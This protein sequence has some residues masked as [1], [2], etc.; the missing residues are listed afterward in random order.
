MAKLRGA[1]Q[2][3]L[4]L[5]HHP[6]PV[7]RLDLQLLDALLFLPSLETG[8]CVYL[9]ILSTPTKHKDL[10]LLHSSQML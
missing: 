5:P 8:L 2:R 7:A 1:T 10:F 9:K 6:F 3:Q 4:F